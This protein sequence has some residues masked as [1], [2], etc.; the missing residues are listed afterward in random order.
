MRKLKT[1]NILIAYNLITILKYLIIG[2]NILFIDFI[3]DFIFLNSM[4][5][6]FCISMNYHIKEN[7]K[8]NIM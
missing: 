4:L 8:Y 2:E 6:I 1:K 3:I 7:A 5:F